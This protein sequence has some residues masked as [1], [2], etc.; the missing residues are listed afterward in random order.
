MHIRNF[1]SMSVLAATMLF[2]QQADQSTRTPSDPKQGADKPAQTNQTATAASGQGHDQHGSAM[3]GSWD[4]KFLMETARGGMAEVRLAQLAQQK[5]SSEEVKQFARQLEQDHTKANEQLKA[6]AQERG[7]Q[8][9][10]DLGQH[11]KIVDMLNNQSGEAFDREFMKAQVKHHKKDISEFRK[12]TNKSMDSDLRNFASS[13]LP[14]LE[15]HL[16]K[17]QTIASQTGTRAR[18]Q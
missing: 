1:L 5:A 17:A 8:L 15:S 16:S 4:S 18:T 13:T 14:T 6:I 11:Q 9:P 12:A 2:A 3:L 7:V 10:T